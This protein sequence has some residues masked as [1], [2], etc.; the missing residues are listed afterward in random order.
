MERNPYSPPSSP[1]SEPSGLS[2]LAGRPAQVSIAALL[3]TASLALGVLTSV[4]L[5]TTIASNSQAAIVQ[6]IVQIF[7]LIVF[8]WLTYKIWVG[9]NWARITFTV[10]AGLGF[11]P[12]IPILMKMFRLSPLAGSINILQT[13]LQLVA[14]YLLFSS[15]G[16]A[17]FRAKS[18]DT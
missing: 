5:P 6:V 11:L 8:L 1:L 18:A 15:P 16:R 3:L 2:V 13:L 4:I 12:Y 10:L 9:R 14:L 7:V 17:W